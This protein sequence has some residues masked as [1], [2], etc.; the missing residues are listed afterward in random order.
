MPNQDYEA[1]DFSG[2][3]N[4]STSPLQLRPN[5][6]SDA[7]NVLPATR[8]AV[9]RRYGYAAYNDTQVASGKRVTGLC[10]FYREGGATDVL[11]AACGGNIY[12]VATTGSSGTDLGNDAD[13]DFT[14]GADVFFAPYRD[15]VYLTAYDTAKEMGCVTEGAAVAD[16]TLQ[17]WDWGVYA[18]SAAPTVAAQAPGN[19]GMSGDFGYKIT[20][21]Y[22]EAG[23]HGESNGGTASATVSPS[24]QDVKVTFFSGSHRYSSATDAINHG[25][26]KVY[27]YRT[28]DGGDTYYYRD[29]VTLTTSSDAYWVDDDDSND[30]LDTSTEPPTD[31]NV[32]DAA[33]YLCLHKERMYIA[34]LHDG[35]DAHPKRVRW[36]NVGYPDV[37]AA[38]SYANTPAEH[39]EIMGLFVLNGA[40]Y[41]ACQSAI[42]RLD[43][44]GATDASFVVV[45]ETAGV[46]APKSLVVGMDGGTS[47]AFF[48]GYDHRVYRFD[49]S[50][51]QPISDDI[52]PILTS[53][54]SQTAM[55][56]CAGGWDGEY[57]Y[58]SYPDDTATLPD[59]E[60]RY[61]TQV[62]KM[63]ERLGY[64]TGTWWPQD[65][66][67]ANC[68]CR[69]DGGS[70][71][72]ELYWGNSAAAGWIFQAN[73][74]ND[75]NGSD[76]EGYLQTGYLNF[77]IS[78]WEKRLRDLLVDVNSYTE[79][80]FKWDMDWD[81]KSGTF[82]VPDSS[83]QPLWGSVT[84]GD[85]Y[86]AGAIP[87][88]SHY[89]FPYHT[90]GLFGRYR[91]SAT[92]GGSP[93]KFY[94]FVQRFIPIRE[95]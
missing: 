78:G 52:E 90:E 88:R 41:I 18:P 57:Y 39:G 92:E 1:Y 19:G 12:S 38:N 50:R 80:A 60:L 71:K 46:K 35:T 13:F 62:Q 45:D 40:L 84:W 87:R 91:V 27:I 85:F 59:A 81:A 73:S 93:W 2:G 4:K 23:A 3:V 63:N 75:D 51:C 58:L 36:S 67:A 95:D 10:R 33:K 43:V 54:A 79:L 47:C 17:C 72:G 49:G 68:Y 44:Y 55:D 34:N 15:R 29:S 53:D 5:E 30:V 7:L 64:M 76:I 86:W 65:S 83:D 21:W 82:T 20:F 16:S 6:L 28:T 66:I 11:L 25:V 9:T 56:T 8:G 14:D 74:G 77:G 61:N 24:S 31:N 32:P 26:G 69:W 22:G 70:D 42:C 94:G 48:L 89:Y 37:Y